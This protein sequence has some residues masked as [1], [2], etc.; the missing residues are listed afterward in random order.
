MP[1]AFP[2]L[3]DQLP[4]PADLEAALRGREDFLVACENT[5]ETEPEIV[6]TAI[7][8]AQTQDGQ[9]LLDAIF[10]NSPFLT[11]CLLREPSWLGRMCLEGTSALAK[12]VIDETRVATRQAWDDACLMRVLRVH[13][14]RIALTVA[15]GDITGSWSLYEVTEALSDFADAAASAAASYVIRRAADRGAFVLKDAENPERGSGYIIIGM[16]KLGARELNYS[17]DIDLICLFD[18]DAIETDNRDGL[19]QHAIRM[20]R[21]LARI[22]DERTADGYVFRV[23]L[24]LRPDLGSTPL[25][26]SVLAAETYYESLGQN[27]ERA[28][29]IKARPIAGDLDAGNDFIDHLRPF[30]WR[31]NL[32]FA[33]I[34]DLSLIHI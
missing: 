29:M 31:K 7:D 27:W 18:A 20:T 19:Q 24:R 12:A 15:I 22:L 11:Q 26:I 25:A 16:G 4:H 33:A 2:I 32:D 28:A 3:R 9:A 6:Q 21:T 30:V 17:S 13:K 23:D 5:A 1:D 8:F 10:G 34:Q 14:R